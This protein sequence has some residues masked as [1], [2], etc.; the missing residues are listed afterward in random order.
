M[1]DVPPVGD[2][3]AEDAYNAAV[4]EG[5]EEVAEQR[6]ALSDR[7]LLFDLSEATP[8]VLTLLGLIA[9]NRSEKGKAFYKNLFAK[10]PDD[11]SLAAAM[12]RGITGAI[13]TPTFLGFG[14]AYAFLD[15]FKWPKFLYE[16]RIQKDKPPPT[17]KHFLKT[18]FWVMVYQTTITGPL[19]SLYM[20]IW[21]K[22]G[23]PSRMRQ[24]PSALRSAA[25]F[26]FLELSF[27]VGFYSAHR[28]LHHPLLYKHIHRQHHTN[29]APFALSAAY[30]HP[31]EQVVANSL[32]F[33]LPSALL[34]V[35][36][37]TQWAWIFWR[38]LE[39]SSAH[40]GYH[41][42]FMPNALFHDNHHSKFEGNYGV[43]CGILI[44]DHLLGTDRR[45]LAWLKR[46]RQA[47]GKVDRRKA[48]EDA[49]AQ[50]EGSK[51]VE[52]RE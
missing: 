38:I 16:T 36:P 22:R 12:Y 33:H 51:P 20:W 41:I 30:A 31:V 27:E 46:Y 15:F 18:I 3:T 42:P 17:L 24:I 10:Y 44:V 4:A 21:T 39:T 29:T 49:A 6:S 47:S 14:L 40:S 8:A 37:S 25:E 1:S 50:A 26:L 28:F 45:Y 48:A 43:N 52:A 35:H 23:G 13:A 7:S 5:P 9:F 19:S 2:A 11:G 34:P 32:P